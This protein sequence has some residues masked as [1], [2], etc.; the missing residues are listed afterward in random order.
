MNSILLLLLLFI[1]NAM[2]II[3]FWQQI[4]QL[5]NDQRWLM[6]KSNGFMNASC[7]H[8]L[9]SYALTIVKFIVKKKLCL[10][11]YCLYIYI[12]KKM[13]MPHSK[14]FY[15]GV[16]KFDATCELDIT[17][18]FINMLWVEAERVRVIFKLTWLTCLINELCSCWTCELVWLV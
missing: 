3:F 12:Y 7:V 10:Y 18:P 6:K 1:Y 9:Q 5:L 8:L 2:D 15:L 16:T 14:T 13:N 17:N 4:L 11:H